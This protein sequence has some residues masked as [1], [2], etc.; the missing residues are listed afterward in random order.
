M[1]FA[2]NQKLLLDKRLLQIGTHTIKGSKAHQLVRQQT[3]GAQR[4]EGTYSTEASMELVLF[5]LAGLLSLTEG[6]SELMCLCICHMT[7]GFHL[8][9]Q[10]ITGIM[11]HDSKPYNSEFN[12]LQFAAWTPSPLTAR[13][14]MSWAADGRECT[15]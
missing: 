8:L 3:A 13:R 1:N 12:L 14:S 10:Y 9:T 15:P 5:L 11:N 6:Q 4:V 7:F 2:T